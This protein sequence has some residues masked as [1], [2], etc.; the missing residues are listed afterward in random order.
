VIVDVTVTVSVLLN[1][2]ET[3]REGVGGGVIVCVSVWE[4]DVSIDGLVV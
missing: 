1:A 2:C 3:E 4:S